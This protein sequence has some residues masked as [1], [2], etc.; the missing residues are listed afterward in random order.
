M[1]LCGVSRVKNCMKM[2]E[3][4]TKNKFAQAKSHLPGEKRDQVLHKDLPKEKRITNPHKSEFL[5]FSHV[6]SVITNE[7]N[8]QIDLAH[9]V[10]AVEILGKQNILCDFEI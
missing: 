3:V 10:A 9:G 4:G 6:G 8:I 7:I 1:E 2:E 5:H